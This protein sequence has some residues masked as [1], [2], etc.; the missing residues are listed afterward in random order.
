MGGWVWGGEGGGVGGGGGVGRARCGA[1]CGPAFSMVMLAAA[2]RLT[3]ERCGHGEDALGGG[4]CGLAVGMGFGIG[5]HPLLAAA[6][7]PAAAQSAP[8]TYSN[9]RGH[10]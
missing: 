2:P 3:L 4:V 1:R 8:A 9:P 7:R 10:C 5:E 6:R